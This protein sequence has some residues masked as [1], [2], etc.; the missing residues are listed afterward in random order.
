MSAALA[1]SRDGDLVVAPLRLDLAL[2]LVESALA[3]RRDAGDVVPDIAAVG[4]ERIVVDADVG[5]EGGVD[6]FGGVGKVLG[7]LAGGIAAGAVD[8]V[9]GDDGQLQ[10]LRRFLQRSAAGAGLLDLVV[11]V[12]DGSLDARQSDLVADLRRHVGEGFGFL[13]DDLRH[14]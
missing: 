12:Q 9:V 7:R 5:G 8:R 3:R 4:L 13:G 2:H 6:H 11:D 1:F 10:F 14:A